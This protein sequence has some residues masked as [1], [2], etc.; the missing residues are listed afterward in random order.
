MRVD[1]ICE[2]CREKFVSKIHCLVHTWTKTRGP[3]GKVH[4]IEELFKPKKD[5]TCTLNYIPNN[6][7]GTCH[8]KAIRHL[9][10]TYMLEYEYH[11]L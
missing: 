8:P 3:T 2:P 5:L 1:A 11:T 4:F 10:D 6:K 7:G 9:H